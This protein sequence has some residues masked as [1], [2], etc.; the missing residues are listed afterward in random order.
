MQKVR[1]PGIR[2]HLKGITMTLANI[3]ILKMTGFLKLLINLKHLFYAS[4]DST[5]IVLQHS[6]SLKALILPAVDSSIVNIADLLSAQ[7]Q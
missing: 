4:R 2:S 5:M 1:G 6:I 7:A 3:V